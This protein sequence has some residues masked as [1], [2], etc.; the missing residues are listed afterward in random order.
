M[1]G[2]RQMSVLVFPALLVGLSAPGSAQSGAEIVDHP[3]K[4]T[5]GPLDFELP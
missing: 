1:I 2:R 4:L 5:Y 3:T